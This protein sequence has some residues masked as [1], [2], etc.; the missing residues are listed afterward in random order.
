MYPW[1]AEVEFAGHAGEQ[2]TRQVID[3]GFEP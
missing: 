2:A 3:G 1:V